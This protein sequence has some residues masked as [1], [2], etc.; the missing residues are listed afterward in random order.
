MLERIAAASGGWPE[1]AFEF[2]ISTGSPSRARSP[3]KSFALIQNQFPEA[4]IDGGAG[5][6]VR[7]FLE[8]FHA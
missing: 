3:A 4:Q 6:H 2:V 5:R 8:G 1:A 7:G